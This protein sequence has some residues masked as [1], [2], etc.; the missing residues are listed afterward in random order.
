ML[1][2]LF[3]FHQYISGN[4]TDIGCYTPVINGCQELDKTLSSKDGVLFVSYS[5]LISNGRLEEVVGWACKNYSVTPSEF[6]GCL[7]FD[8]CHRAKIDIFGSFLV[9]TKTKNTNGE[10]HHKFQHFV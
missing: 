3:C 2:P 1:P 7:I 5:T 10:E 6:D 8:E 4:G 9:H